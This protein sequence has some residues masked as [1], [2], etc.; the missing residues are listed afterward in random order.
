MGK[1]TTTTT[2]K[3]FLRAKEE[4]G[5]DCFLQ[6]FIIEKNGGDDA[7]KSRSRIKNNF[8]NKNHAVQYN[9]SINRWV[10][11]RLY[12]RT[13]GLTRRLPTGLTRRPRS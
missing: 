3:C 5:D 10:T 7:L 6:T 9:Q 2:L 1:Q 12:V 8:K 13:T 11:L 4:C